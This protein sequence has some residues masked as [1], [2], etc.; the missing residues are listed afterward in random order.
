MTYALHFS[1]QDW[2]RLESDWT[3]W[4][5]GELER[6]MVVIENPIHAR[7]PDELSREFLLDTP[8]EQV[9]EH[10]NRRLQTKQIFGDAWPKWWPFFGAGVVA[11]FLGADLHCSPQSETI[12]FEPENGNITGREKFDYDANNIWFQRIKT[13]TEAAV[14]LW[15]EKVCVGLT[16]LGGNLDILAS[17]QTSQALLLDLY[18]KPEMVKRKSAEVRGLWLRYYDELYAITHKSGR[19]AT[20]WAPIWA[21]GRCY[22]LQSDFSAMISPQMFETFVLP[23]LAACCDELDFTFYH[24]DGRGQINHLEHL[25]SLE[26]LHGVQWIPG[27]GQ[28][29][30]AAWLPLLQRIIEAG[31]LCQ[32]YVSAQDAQTIM[33]ELGGRGFAFYI[34]ENLNHD[35]AKQLVR[36]LTE[37]STKL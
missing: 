24:M 5:A 25:L 29:S 1:E 14:E 15:G 35:E 12:W 34:T 11:A 31:K 37:R 13:L 17:L 26:N 2:Q 22:M 19:G 18:D 28:P 10:Y 8:V 32:L 3:A 21:P 9:L 23:D 33:R 27:E 16:D 7:L 6:P 4:W 20:P 36:V 30:P